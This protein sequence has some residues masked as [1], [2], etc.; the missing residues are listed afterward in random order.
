MHTIRAIL[1]AAIGSACYAEQQRLSFDQIYET[2]ELIFDDARIPVAQM[3]EVAWLSPYLSG[4]TPMAPFEM[5]VSETRMPDGTDVVD[6]IF[7][8]PWLELCVDLP[9][10]RCERDPRVPDAAFMQNAARNLQ[11]GDEQVDALLHMRLPGVLAPVRA[12]LLEHLLLSVERERYRYEYLKSGD[13]GPMRKLLCRECECGTPEE[14]LLAMLQTSKDPEL[15]LEVSVRWTQALF[16]CE[17]KTH[18]FGYPIT[19]WERFLKDFGILER[20]ID[21]RP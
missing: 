12:Y 13:I 20:R 7:Y 17:L 11:R 15:K 8:A 9:L 5:A 19:A 4:G 21:K 18:P 16:Q 2:Y 6:K 10:A 14:S 1:I 3:R